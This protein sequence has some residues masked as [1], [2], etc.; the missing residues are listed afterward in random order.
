MHILEKSFRHPVNSTHQKKKS[1]ATV[2]RRSTLRSQTITADNIKYHISA[3]IHKIG[4]V[5]R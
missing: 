4:N 5:K 2:R 1:Y 3:I